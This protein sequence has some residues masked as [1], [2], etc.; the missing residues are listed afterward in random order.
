MQA[1]PMPKPEPFHVFISHASDDRNAAMV[2][3]DRLE[4]A[5]I[6]CWIAPRNIPTGE[7]WAEHIDAAIHDAGCV[8]VLISDAAN[9]STPVGNEVDLA[10]KYTK[11]IFPVRLEDV[12]LGPRLR[13][14]INALQWIDAFHRALPDVADELAL[15]LLDPRRQVQAFD[16]LLRH[17][18]RRFVTRAAFAT[19]ATVLALLLAYPTVKSLLRSQQQVARDELVARGLPITDQA[20]ADAISRGDEPALKLFRQAGLGIP[21]LRRATSLKGQDGAPALFDFFRVASGNPALQTWFTAQLEAGLP[22]SFPV[23]GPHRPEARP[24]WLAV[25]AGNASIAITLLHHGANPYDPETLEQS[26]E[27]GPRFIFPARYVANFAEHL[28]A[29]DRKALILAMY[30]ANV[31]MPLEPPDGRSRL[32]EDERDALHAA[33]PDA[34]ADPPLCGALPPQCRSGKFDAAVCKWLASLP[35]QLVPPPRGLSIPNRFS[36]GQFMALVDGHAWLRGIELIGGEATTIVTSVPRDGG[37][38][39]VYR[40]TGGRYSQGL[41]CPDMRQKYPYIDPDECWISFAFRLASAD[42]ASF[43]VGSWS[44]KWTTDSTCV[45]N[46]HSAPK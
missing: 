30:N 44:E 3:V 39:N 8:V 25:A 13:L 24:F 23:R 27:N 9:R 16:A 11:P 18:R 37:T 4:A 46:G 38:W 15:Q 14:Y 10:F 1:T 41:G 33:V 35:A 17:R 36:L 34:A 43:E 29:E 28:S 12:E 5:S 40:R 26:K 21:A 42:N 31:T 2:I 45:S 6:R 7:H 22:A 32:I 19:V 20:L